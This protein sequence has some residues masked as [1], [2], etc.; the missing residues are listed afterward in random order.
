[1]LGETDFRH[2][3]M[4]AAMLQFLQR[5]EGAIV[6]VDGKT[7]VLDEAFCNGAGFCL[8]VCPTGALTVEERESDFKPLWQAADSTFFQSPWKSS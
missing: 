3:Q 6:L 1:M 5:A 7:R 8:A 4:A 2:T